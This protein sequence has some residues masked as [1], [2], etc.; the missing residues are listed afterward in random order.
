[1]NTPEKYK[2]IPY[3]EIINRTIIPINQTKKQNVQLII[4]KFIQYLKNKHL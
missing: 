1:M 2:S 4:Q 3:S